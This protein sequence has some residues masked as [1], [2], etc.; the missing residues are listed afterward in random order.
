MS[1][2]L[3]LAVPSGPFIDLNTG[4]VTPAWRQFLV[5]LA[6]RTG[7]TQGLA[8]PDTAPIEADLAAEQAA[9]RAGDVTL[10][11]GIAAEAAARQAADAELAT[12]INR[13]VAKTGDTMLGP[14][15]TQRLG[16]NGAIPPTK[17]TVTGAKGGNAALASLLTALVAY[18]LITDSTSA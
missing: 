12:A 18:G 4:N 2:S 1:G 14:L 10:T 6:Q 16:V 7:G 5:V 11:T 8:T 15:T 13:R 3:T 9:R 17:Q